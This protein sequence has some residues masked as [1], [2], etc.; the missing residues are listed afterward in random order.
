[1]R[2][3][4]FSKFSKRRAVRAADPYALAARVRDNGPELWLVM[5]ACDG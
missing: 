1:M 2:A 5:V 3:V 4:G